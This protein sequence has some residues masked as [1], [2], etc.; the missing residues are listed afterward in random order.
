MKFPPISS[1]SL[2]L[3]SN[4][5]ILANL[6][7]DDVSCFGGNDGIAYSNTSGGTAP[8]TYFWSVTGS[9]SSSSTGLNA[10]TSY[11]VQITDANNCPT[12]NTIFTVSQPDSISMFVSI[13]SVSCFLGTDGQIQIDSVIGAVAPYTYLWSNGQTG[14]QLNNLIPGSYNCIVTDAIGCVDSSNTFTVYQPNELFASISITSNYNGIS[15]NC[16]GDSTAE[17]T[18][19]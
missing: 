9:N 5:P 17:L 8:Y 12:S 10:Y 18:V 11:S 4:D 16:Y 3:S 15:L 19:I 2:F 14:L 13:D 1:L 7:F 6:S